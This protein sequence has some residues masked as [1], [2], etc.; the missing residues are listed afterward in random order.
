MSTYGHLPYYWGK[1]FLTSALL[2]SSTLSQALTSLTGSAGNLS[3]DAIK[4]THSHIPGE[5]K[6]FKLS[7]SVHLILAFNKIST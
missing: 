3:A 4:E 5:N 7:N 6:V 2:H 1:L